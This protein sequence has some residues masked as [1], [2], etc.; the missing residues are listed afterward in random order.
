MKDTQRH[1]EHF[2]NLHFS[3]V[4]FYLGTSN[5]ATNISHYNFSIIPTTYNVKKSV[6][7]ME[8]AFIPSTANR[9]FS[10]IL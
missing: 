5:L 3:T 1:L 2:P 8:P 9:L 7:I 4:L 6:S 10:M